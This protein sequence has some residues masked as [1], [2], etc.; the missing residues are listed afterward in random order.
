MLLLVRHWQ[1][2]PDS[3]PPIKSEVAQSLPEKEGNLPMSPY[4]I[5]DVELRKPT[6]QTNSEHMVRT[7]GE[8]RAMPTN[9]QAL[10]T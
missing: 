4:S 2:W 8:G 3:L 10:L 6:L 5:G 7:Y 1:T 9:T